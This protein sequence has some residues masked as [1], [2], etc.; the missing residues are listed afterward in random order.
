MVKNLGFTLIFQFLGQGQVD[1]IPPIHTLWMAPRVVTIHVDN[2]F[3]YL[4]I[5]AYR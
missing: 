2:F 3:I 4:F 5:Y 1:T